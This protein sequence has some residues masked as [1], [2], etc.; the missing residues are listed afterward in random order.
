MCA[1][2]HDMSSLTESRSAELD[3][4]YS[5]VDEVPYFGYNFATEAVFD[6]VATWAPKR[7]KVGTKLSLDLPGREIIWLKVTFSGSTESC[8]LSE[9]G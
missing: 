3:W 9:N 4:G 7:L 1:S 5:V 2:D 8:G 6:I